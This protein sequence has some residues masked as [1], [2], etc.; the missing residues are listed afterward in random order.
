MS[1]QSFDTPAIQAVTLTPE[2]KTTLAGIMR[3]EPNSMIGRWLKKGFTT[4]EKFLDANSL[5]TNFSSQAIQ[6]LIERGLI[7]P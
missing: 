5:S 3:D 7:E 1:E 2:L 4:P 6:E